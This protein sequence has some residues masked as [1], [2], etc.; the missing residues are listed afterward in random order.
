MND[1]LYRIRIDDFFWAGVMILTCI[2]YTFAVLGLLRSIADEISC[3]KSKVTIGLVRVRP[4]EDI[5]QVHW[6]NRVDADGNSQTSLRRGFNYLA[7]HSFAVILSII[8]VFVVEILLGVKAEEWLWGG[9]NHWP[10]GNWL[11]LVS[12]TF[13]AIASCF[14]CIY[15]CFGSKYTR[16]NAINY[17]SNLY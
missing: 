10:A 12:G 14:Q 6:P 8:C 5:D 1:L 3:K 2:L 9:P 13:S 7:L 4:G 16:L 11:I 17:I 15:Q